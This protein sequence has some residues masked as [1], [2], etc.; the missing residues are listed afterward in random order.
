VPATRTVPGAR[1]APTPASGHAGSGHASG[2]K[3]AASPIA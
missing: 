3:A 2:V 1:S